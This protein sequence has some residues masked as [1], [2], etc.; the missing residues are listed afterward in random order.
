VLSREANRS[1]S[2][3]ILTSCRAAGVSP[4]LVEMPDDDIE[5]ALLTAASGAGMALLPEAVA[6]RYGAPGVRFVPLGVT[7][8]PLQQR[9]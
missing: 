2:D 7:R 9:S 3:G 4:M 6:D 8:R 1:L 5:Q